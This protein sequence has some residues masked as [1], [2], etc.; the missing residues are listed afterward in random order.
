VPTEARRAKRKSDDGVDMP[1]AK[2]EHKRQWSREDH[3]P[4]NGFVDSSQI[5]N[6]Q[7]ALVNPYDV[8]LDDEIEYIVPKKQR[9]QT[10]NNGSSG[11]QEKRSNSQ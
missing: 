2:K 7:R 9:T 4:D 3:G 6:K 8:L 5:P 11:A 1:Q 10:P